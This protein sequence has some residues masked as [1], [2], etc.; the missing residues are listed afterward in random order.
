M[1]TNNRQKI[2]DTAFAL[3]LAN[4]S[5][6]ALCVFFFGKANHFFDPL[7]HSDGFC[8]S[9]QATPLLGSHHLSVY[10]NTIGAATTILLYLFFKDRLGLDAENK[11]LLPN[12]LG[13]FAHGVGHG[14]IA[15]GN[16]QM[17]GNFEVSVVLEIA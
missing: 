8:V 2:G 12:A 9:N 1:S 6:F 15:L 13:A 10:I 7:W 16:L 14:A 5:L 3:C 17:G 4:T 11:T